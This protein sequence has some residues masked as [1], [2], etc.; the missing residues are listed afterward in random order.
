MSQELR[1]VGKEVYGGGV[2]M[3]VD[4]EGYVEMTG[5]G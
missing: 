5:V 4:E 1:R 2:E 3:I